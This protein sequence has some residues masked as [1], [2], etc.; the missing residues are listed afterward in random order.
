MLFLIANLAVS[1]QSLAQT[2]KTTKPSTS[3]V[4]C[5]QRGMSGKYAGSNAHPND[6]ATAEAW[7]H[8]H[9]YN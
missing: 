4:K 6:R 2:T 5:V 7:C 8:A 3:F 9:G 1:S